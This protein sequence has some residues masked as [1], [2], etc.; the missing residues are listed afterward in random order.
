M[1]KDSWSASDLALLAQQGPQQLQLH[2]EKIRRLEF[3]F[4]DAAHL[5]LLKDVRFP[6]LERV[7]LDHASGVHHTLLGQPAAGVTFQKYRFQNPYYGGFI[8]A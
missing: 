7:V 5:V 2:A 8:I 1:T 3:S 6:M 4:D